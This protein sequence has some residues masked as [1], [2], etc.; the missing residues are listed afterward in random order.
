[1]S[2]IFMYSEADKKQIHEWNQELL[3]KSS[4]SSKRRV[5]EKVT[6]SKKTKK[7]EVAE[8][9]AEQDLAELF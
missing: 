4:S 5:I 7:K 1:M 3:S 2:F 9:D 8:K 6:A